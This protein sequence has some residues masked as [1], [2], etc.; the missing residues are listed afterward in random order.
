MN[1]RSPS[2]WQSVAARFT[3]KSGTLG[4]VGLG[5]VGLPLCLAAA[6]SGLKVIGFDVDPAKPQ[7]LARGLT[8]LSHIG[9]ETV[10]AAIRTGR[11]TAT[12]DFARLDEPDAL[13]I[14]VPTPL[15]A[16]LE[17]DLSFVVA[18]AEQIARRLR[19]G[20]IV[21]LESTTYP[22]TTDEV[23]R[24]I[25]ERT[26]LSC[27]VDFFLAF[28]PEREDPGN[29][30][31]STSRIPKVVGADS[32]GALAIAQASPRTSSA[33]STSPSSTSSRSSTGPWASTC[34]R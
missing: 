9:D 13:L 32:E 24:P 5:Y 4:V 30:D 23:V 19:R 11:F 15:T 16:H 27:D 21:V 20:Q 28:S 7:A 34:G 18:T 25:L 31:F 3:D 8:Y 17:P 1:D 2:T 12:T 10:A 33:P 14:C 26:G 6:K 22:G 29:I